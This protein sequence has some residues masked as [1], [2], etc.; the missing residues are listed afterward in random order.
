[1]QT[2]T[3]P[4]AGDERD[5]LA[6][7]LGYKHGDALVSA[8]DRA[9]A[10]ISERFASLAPGAVVSE[11][12]ERI[13]AILSALD[14]QSTGESRPSLPSDELLVALRG[15]ARRPG[16]PLGGN[17]RE[18]HP[19]FARGLV[20]AILDAADPE[21]AANTVR[22]F[23][24]RL[25]APGVD[26]Y[27]R[28]LGDDERALSRF[29]GLCGTSA[30][31]GRGLVGHP[32]LADVLLFSPRTAGE[33]ASR[34]AR[35]LAEEIARLSHVDRQDA[36]SFVGATRRAKAAL[37]LDVG[38]R[39]LASEI[40]TREACRAL[41]V[42][43]DATID[44]ATTWALEEAVR[45]R[46]LVASSGAP[47]SLR[48]FA[49]LALGSLG[50]RELGYG[51]DLDVVFVYDPSAVAPFGLDALDAGELFGR[52]AQRVIRLIGTL[53]PDGPG[54]ELDTR[55]R[56]SGEQG[57]LVVSLDAF[58][59]Y[60]MGTDPTGRRAADWERQALVRLRPC[61]GDL[62]LAH[63]AT[64][65]AHVAAYELGPPDRD[66]LLR[67]RERM[68][69]EIAKE[70]EGR[71]DPKL[72]RGGLVDVELAVQYLQ[73]KHGADRNVRTT[74]LGPAIDALEAGGHLR[75][76][77]AGVFRDGHRF[78]RRLE[79]RARV[80]HGSRAVLLQEGAP[81]LGPLARSMGFRDGPSGT[82]Q[83][84]LTTKYREVTGEVRAAFLEVLGA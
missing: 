39:D 15:L 20:A 55:L 23:F 79:Q 67:I 8:L 69:T 1:M 37:E 46:Q 43:A 41:T 40:D 17:T 77:N 38:L 78:L 6:R 81:G 13:D 63:A 28:A 59:S 24:D 33:D 29:V 3:L 21:L 52:V 22:S 57:H 42:M 10:R 75:P 80:V 26:A 16:G 53:H 27:V 56:P 11:A 83:E 32:E 54:Y 35:L 64:E 36:E 18:R 65:V 58:R 71:Y 68:E 60:H 14:I 50:A 25:S 44:A 5:R 49:V 61:A 2:H 72:G 4:I 47:A 84:L 82:A 70:R 45:R 34:G 19:K 66:E 31:L 76:A 74:E 30:Y 48:G 7:S 62:R 9:R 12:E 73:M 51:S